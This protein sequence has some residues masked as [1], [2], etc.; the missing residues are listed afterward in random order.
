MK[1]LRWLTSSL[2]CLD[3]A[4]LQTWDPVSVHCR[5][6]PVSVF[7]KRMQR[8]AVPPPEASRPCWW[9][10]QAMAFTA[11]KCSVYCCTGRTLEWFHTSSYS[12]AAGR[13]QGRSTERWHSGPLSRGEQTQRRNL[14]SYIPCCRFHLRRA[15][16]GPCST[17]GH[18]LPACGPGD[19]ALIEGAG[20]W[21]HAARSLDRDSQ[22]TAGRR[23]TP[24]PL[25]R[26]S[27]EGILLNMTDVEY[28]G[29][30][31]AKNAGSSVRGKLLHS[32]TRAVCPSSTDSF[33]PA[34]ASQICT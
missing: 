31:C 30:G 7:Q 6:W 20:L 27:N 21:C 2:V 3:Q 8:S 25:R 18:R 4:R 17:W 29:G 23:S 33:F 12:R 15:V 22:T 13:H 10:D 16:G 14:P 28:G 9:G 24:T 11:A 1:V 34:D 19:G 26:N 32:P 5:V